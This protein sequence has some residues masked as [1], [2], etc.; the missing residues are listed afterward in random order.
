[1]PTL[2][3]LRL[4]GEVPVDL[5]AWSVEQVRPFG[6]ALSATSGWTRKDGKMAGQRLPHGKAAK[7]P[8]RG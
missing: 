8:R 3:G 6:E 1:M 5:S 2:E 7:R 4:L